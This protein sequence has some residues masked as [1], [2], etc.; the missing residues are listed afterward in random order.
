[1]EIQNN[2]SSFVFIASILQFKVEVALYINRIFTICYRMTGNIEEA[3]DV[4]KI[5]LWRLI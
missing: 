2:S 5:R 3:K 4:P 1:M